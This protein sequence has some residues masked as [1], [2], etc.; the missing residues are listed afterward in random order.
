M[1]KEK[2]YK[3]MESF[4]HYYSYLYDQTVDWWPSGRSC[5]TAKLEDGV[6]IEFDYVS[7]TIRRIQPNNVSKDIE[8]LRKEIGFNIKKLVQTRGMAQSDI[9]KQCDI[10]EAMLSRYIHGT[11]MP[12]VD[13][14]NALAATLDCRVV[15]IIGEYYGD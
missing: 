5:I 3:I 13:K 7:T 8:T 1:K 10:T 11:S 12:S 14:I 15:D 9:A 4:E 6:L 2:Y